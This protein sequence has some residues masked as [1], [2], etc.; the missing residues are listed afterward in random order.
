[1]EKIDQLAEIF[2]AIAH[3]IRLKIAMGLM[4]KDNC[5]VNTMVEKLNISQPN[6]SQ[7]LNILKNAGIIQGY[8]Q[9]TQ[10]CYKLVND[11]V[12]KILLAIKDED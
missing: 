12:K 4:Q 11:D 9:G 7:H 2:K 10:I 6:V 8:R 5:N 1:M 3:P